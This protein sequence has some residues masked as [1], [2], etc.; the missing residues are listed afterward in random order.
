VKDT[1]ITIASIT[2]IV[3]GVL[4]I[5]QYFGVT[6][7]TLGHALGNLSPTVTATYRE[8]MLNFVAGLAVS[9]IAAGVQFLIRKLERN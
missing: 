2:T 9:F 8:L 3:A 6:S 7:G 5:L 4:T 1:I